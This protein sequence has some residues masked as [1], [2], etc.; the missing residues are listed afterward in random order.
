M[1]ATGQVRKIVRSG[2]SQALDTLGRRVARTCPAAFGFWR[3]TSKDNRSYH[4][5][6]LDDPTFTAP[7][8]AN[9]FEGDDA[10]GEGNLSNQHRL[11]GEDTRHR[12]VRGCQGDRDHEEGVGE[13]T[14]GVD[15]GHA[16]FAA[17]VDL[18]GDA[19][20][21]IDRGEAQ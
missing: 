1:A 8:Y 4:S 10:T 20:G 6:K 17:L 9:L 21:R 14:G 16:G 15:A 18:E 3:R 2:R 7:I 5:V 13:V 12:A 11:L 19:D